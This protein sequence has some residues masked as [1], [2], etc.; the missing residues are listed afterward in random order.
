MFDRDLENCYV[1]GTLST[2]YN[3]ENV[4]IGF[5]NLKKMQILIDLDGWGKKNL[6]SETIFYKIFGT[7]LQTDRYTFPI[8]S[9]LAII[10]LN[11]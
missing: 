4:F 11:S 6:S 10:F 9:S 3:N 7:N 1:T 5:K 8:E 2:I